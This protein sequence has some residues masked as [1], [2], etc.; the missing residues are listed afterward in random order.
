MVVPNKVYQAAAAGR[1]LVTRD[2]PA[3]REVLRPGEH[4]VAVSAARSRAR[5]RRAVA[6]LLDD[7]ARAERLGAAARAHVLERFAPERAGGSACGRC[8]PTRLGVRCRPRRGAAARIGLSRVRTAAVVVS[9]EGGATTRALRGLAARAGP[10]AVRDRRRRQRVA[11]RRARRGCGAARR[12]C[13]ASAAPARREPAV[14]RRPQRRRAGGVRGA[15]PSAAAPPQQRHGARAR[16]AR[17]PRG[18]ARR[19]AG[20]RASPARASSTS[21][22]PTHVISA[23]ERALAAAPLRA[24]HAAP[25]PRP[26]GDAPY[27]VSGVMGCALL[28]TRACFEAVGGFADG[29][30]GLLR[31]RRLLPRGARA[32]ASAPSSCRAP[33]SATTACAA[34]RPG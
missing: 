24:A 5:S 22:I 20:G 19:R 25:L 30:R 9:W 8:W 1:P 6:R 13:R 23:G 21:A 33:S 18:R 11:E 15:A 26:R 31:G 28:V 3:L 2:G 29:D 10:A 27:P 4:C 7:P 32:P 14:R 12:A 34:S 17:A 16:R